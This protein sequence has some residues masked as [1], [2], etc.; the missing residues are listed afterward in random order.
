MATWVP[1]ALSAATFRWPLAQRIDLSFNAPHQLRRDD[2][3]DLGQPEDGAERRALQAPLQ[4]ADVRGVIAGVQPE[5]LLG[6][7]AGAAERAERLA[8]G[9]LRGHVRALRSATQPAASAS[10]QWLK[11]A[12][13]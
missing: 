10:V 13:P 12:T 3:Q 1:P 7:A 5:P 11:I 8:E 4:L 2:T 9:L 6:E